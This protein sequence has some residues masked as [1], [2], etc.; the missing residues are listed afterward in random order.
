MITASAISISSVFT[1]L[2][3][4]GAF[5]S[6][7]PS[8]ASQTSYF[9][10]TLPN[11]RTRLEGDGA[12]DYTTFW[13]TLLLAVGSTTVTQSMVTSLIG[14]LTIVPLSLGASTEMR[15]VVKQEAQILRKLTGDGDQDLVETMCSVAL[16][17]DWNEGHARVIV[18]SLSESEG[19]SQDEG[20]SLTTVMELLLTIHGQR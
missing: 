16:A 15:R 20:N 18:C 7:A 1:K 6:S 8:L 19:T 13:S 17:K 10:A 9:S 2:S 4:L 5:P 12:S 11:I 3:R 14:H